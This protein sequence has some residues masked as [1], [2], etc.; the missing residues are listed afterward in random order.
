MSAWRFGLWFAKVWGRKRA[1]DKTCARPLFFASS[2]W[3][4]RQKFLS[5]IFGVGE[6]KFLC[7]G[8][9]LGGR[10]QNLYRSIIQFWF[11]DSVQ[12]LVTPQQHRPMTKNRGKSGTLTPLVPWYLVSFSRKM[13]EKRWKIRSNIFQQGY[14]TYFFRV[15][16][17]P[18]RMI[19]RLLVPTFLGVSIFF[20]Y[21]TLLHCTYL[22]HV[23][24]K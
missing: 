3:L 15:E 20:F 6:V 22:P 23:T 13:G 1:D 2:Q 21:F 12:K 24:G 16:N 17:C 19:R 11:P 5:K 4:G 8:N 7:T 18:S 10:F 9:F 14:F